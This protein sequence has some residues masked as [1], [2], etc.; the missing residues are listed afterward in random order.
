MMDQVVNYALGFLFWLVLAKLAPPDTIGQVMVA[1]AVAASVLGFAGYGA[2]VT[3]SKYIAEY[4][5]K[6]M[7]MISKEVFRLGLKIGVIVSGIAALAFALLSNQIATLFFNNSSL[8]PLILVSSL[9][10]LPSQTILACF[11]GA[12]QGSQKMKYTALADLL[13]QVSRLSIAVILVIIGFA[14][15]GIILG[16][17]F[18]SIVA[19]FFSYGLVV[20]KLFKSANDKKEPMDLRHVARF[21]GLNYLAIGISTLS[22]Q[23][24]YLLLGTQSFGSVAIFGIS[25]LISGA[26]GGI[27]ISVSKAILPATSEGWHR[28]NMLDFSRMINSAFRISIMASGFLYL[29]LLIVPEG[30]LYLLSKEYTIGSLSLQILVVAAIMSSLTGL[31]GSVLNGIGKARAVVKI[32]VSA[33]IAIIVSTIALV[34]ILGIEGAALSMLIGSS[35]GLALSLYYIKQEKELILSFRNLLRPIICVVSSLLVGYIALFVTDNAIFSLALSF[36]AYL[37]L[38]RSFRVISNSEISGLLHVATKAIGLKL[39]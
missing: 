5:A 2:Q 35:L 30:V 39:K 17:A 4:N 7:G 27:M 23:L 37:I 32:S 16:F 31:I 3:I 14:S 20:K 29:V 15:L 34:P 25:A 28:G 9:I 8:T 19:V 21:S 38:V 6:D 11:N 18:G 22:V 1:T 10:F 36:A 26:V 24:G 13:Y 12:F 33:A